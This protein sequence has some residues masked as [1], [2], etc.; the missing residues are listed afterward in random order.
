M[1]VYENLTKN[2]QQGY[3]QFVIHIY[4]DYKRRRQV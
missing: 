4:C 1:S 3:P 2:H